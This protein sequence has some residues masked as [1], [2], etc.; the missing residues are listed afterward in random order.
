MTRLERHPILEINN[1]HKWPQEGDGL[2]Q[3]KKTSIKHNASRLVS[4]KSNNY[5]K[6]DIYYEIKRIMNSKRSRISSD[7][8]KS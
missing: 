2:I 7:T 1:H 5:W 3:G 8:G 6:N 4:I